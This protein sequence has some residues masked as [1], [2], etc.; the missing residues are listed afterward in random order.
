[1][2]WKAAN[3]VLQLNINTLHDQQVQKLTAFSAL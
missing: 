3:G 1:M 2:T